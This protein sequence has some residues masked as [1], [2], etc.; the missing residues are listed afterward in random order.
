MS[1]YLSATVKA[2]GIDVDI[3]V[4]GQFEVPVPLRKLLRL[5]F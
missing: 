2:G 1:Y 4:V 3:N 5:P